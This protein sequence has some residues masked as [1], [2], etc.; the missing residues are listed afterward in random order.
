MFRPP[1]V[2]NLTRRRSLAFTIVE[3]LV[4][5][6]VISI[7]STLAITSLNSTLADSDRIVARRNAQ[8]IANISAAAVSGGSPVF[9]G[10][11]DGDLDKA[12]RRVHANPIIYLQKDGKP[13]TFNIGTYSKKDL[14]KAKLY[15]TF[16]SGR[17]IYNN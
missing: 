8:T 1:T 14:A 6:T 16:Q 9:Q 12:I 5:I 11:A 10:V 4:V 2:R 17:L 13:I 7:L 3:L 15:L